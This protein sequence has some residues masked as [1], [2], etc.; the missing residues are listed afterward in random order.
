MS[1]YDES[2]FRVRDENKN[3]VIDA[4]EEDDINVFE[5][6][7]C[8]LTILGEYCNDFMSFH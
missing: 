5:Q 7:K 1:F 8:P 6:L 3:G 2:A 4:S